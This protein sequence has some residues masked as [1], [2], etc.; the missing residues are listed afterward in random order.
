LDS[1]TLLQA[2]LN[3]IG[4][5]YEFIKH[6]GGGTYSNVYLVRHTLFGEDY[7]LKIMDYHFIKQKFKKESEEDIKKK[8]QE[9]KERFIIEARM[10]KKLAHPNIVRIYDIDFIEDHAEEVDIPYFIMDYIKGSTLA[11]IIKNKAPM[12]INTAVNISVDI[13]SALDAIHS[14]SIIHRDLKP[15]NIMVEEETGKAVLIDLG[16]AKD[17]IRQSD[18]TTDGT[19]MGSPG[20]MAPEQFY[21][22]VKVGTEADVYS[23]GVVLY[24]MLT[25]ELP[26]NDAN[27]MKIMNSNRKKFPLDLRKKNPALPHGIDPVLSTALA[28]DPAYRYKN[29]R[30]FL[31]AVRKLHEHKF[32]WKLKQLRYLPVL[33]LI[34]LIAI[35]IFL[36]PLNIA[37]K[38]IHKT[39]HN[40]NENKEN[41]AVLP[42]EKQVVP[43]PVQYIEKPVTPV[44]QPEPPVPVPS[45]DTEAEYKRHIEAVKKFIQGGEYIKAADSLGKARDIKN[46]PEVKQLSDEI[47]NKRIEFELSNGSRE[48]EAIKD[49]LSLTAYLSFKARYPNSIYL[50]DLTAKMKAADKNL[51]PEKYWT[52]SLKSNKKGLYEFTFGSE[53][54]GHIMIYIPGKRIWIDKYEV[55]N[56]QYRRYLRDDKIEF[57]RQ[58]ANKFIH[59]GDEYP[60]VVS[61]E[62]AGRYCKKYG[63]RLPSVE[64]WEYAAGAGKNIYPWGNEPPDS[65]STWHANIDT[66][67]GDY[68]KDGFKGTAP[69]KSFEQF[70]SPFGAVNMAGNVWEW[71]QGY[72]LKGGG[73][74]SGKE[75]LLIK[76]NLNGGPNEKEGFRCVKDE[77]EIPK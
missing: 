16:I 36:D 69:V 72:I 55:S 26:Y 44:K 57:V 34:I 75:D 11:G 27:Y 73:F 35:F 14:S 48:Y 45:V 18:L 30:E 52:N 56:M 60:V 67:D 29:A 28:K 1:D 31:D 25:G 59:N 71:V 66:L 64:E 5:K 22:S 13:L 74:F 76:K 77:N 17:V 21:K 32:K 46:T 24:E 3:K 40:K 4:K 41:K 65:D 19:L 6:V 70:F 47:V 63:F 38:T 37:H 43:G 53:N 54:N 49:T 42:A 39:I 68:E 2:V 61:Y 50:P 62:D 23:F 7:A 51:P 58:T 10:Y 9:I 20:Y 8:F 33:L 15:A 12:E